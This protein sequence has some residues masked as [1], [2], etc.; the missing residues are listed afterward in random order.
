MRHRLLQAP[1]WV[2]SVVTGSTFGLFWVLWSR[3]LE[4]ESWSEALAVGGLLGLFFGAVMGP[5]LH[6]QNRGVREAAERSPEG[7]SPRVRRAASRGPVPAETE[8]RRAAHELALAQLGPLERQRAWGPP[9]FLFMA[10]VAVGLAST[11]SAWW[12]LGAAFFVAIAAG[13]RYQLVRLRRRVALLDP[14][15]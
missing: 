14:E 8:V 1:V 11:E 5:V 15:G 3:L 12:W 13:H 7:L 4:G 6:R 10:A 9:F 2:L